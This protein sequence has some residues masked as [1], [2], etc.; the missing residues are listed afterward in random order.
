MVSTADLTT[1]QGLRDYLTTKNIEH[2]TVTLLTGGTANYVY[3]VLLSDGR[4][5]IYKHAAPYLHSNKAFAFDPTRMNYEHRILTALPPVL[6]A[7]LPDSAVRP[8]GCYS[9]DQEAKLL[10]I[11]D[12]GERELKFAYSDRRLDVKKIGGELGRWIA[13]LHTCSTKLSLSLKDEEDLKANNRIGVAIYRHSYQNLSTALANFGHDVELGKY[14]NEEFGSRLATEDECVCHGDFWPGNVLVQPRESEEDVKLTVVDWEMTR[15]GTSAT[16]VGQFAAEA[17]LL[18]R[19]RRGKGLLHAF[20]NAYFVARKD[21]I[22]KEW[23]KRMV[24]HWAVHIAFWPTRVEW[25]NREGT[26]E[27]VD[28]G[29]GVLRAVVEDNW[30][31]LRASE[32]LRRIEIDRNY[33]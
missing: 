24:V 28:I 15:R 1:E 8:V 31:K 4:A 10:C 26:K 21:I 25:T 14:I 6:K 23:V 32:P 20:L 27:L 29:V 33:S 7:Q 5:V 18:D 9:Y 2:T 22:G 17:F 19:F 13:A 30:E 12:G 11:E 3:R 16:D